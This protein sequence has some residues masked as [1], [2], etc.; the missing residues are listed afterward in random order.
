M[1]KKSAKI[2]LK[3]VFA[4]TLCLIIVG[5]LFPE[6]KA[7]AATPFSETNYVEF[8]A[9]KDIPVYVNATCSVRGTFS[10][11]RQ[12]NRTISKNDVCK[13]FR[14]TT[15][16]ITIAYPTSQG[17][18]IGFIRTSDLLF[19]ANVKTVSTKIKATTYK[20]INGAAYGTT[21]VGD[22]VFQCGS[23]NGWTQII[24]SAK[25]GNR[26]WKL[27]YIPTSVYN[28]NILGEPAT[29][30]LTNSSAVVQK[31]DLIRSGKLSIDGNTIMREGATFT[32][33]RSSEQCKGYVRNIVLLTY[34]INI[35][36]T[37]NNNY[38]LN[39]TPKFTEV[40]SS[41]NITTNNVKNWFTN[42]NV[43]PGSVLQLRRS[44]HGGPHSAVVYS[45][46][47]DGCYLLE[48]NTDGRNSIT[49]K[50][51]TYSAIA[52]KNNGLSIYTYT[53]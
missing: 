16:S 34:G 7:S 17:E 2:I 38:Q 8:I 23:K 27:A 19:S 50:Y 21:T 42:C 6:T 26:G 41:T 9:D 3:R 36:S 48:A 29:S 40:V 45:I 18:R 13:V 43:S 49:C 35:S 51:Y 24:Y 30:S 10:P 14:F 1:L 46:S 39:P 33:T 44:A 47:N 12:Y 31:L 25:S 22:N 37:K 4:F 20:S 15:T 5:T 52:S 53:G 32:G 28:S 11:S